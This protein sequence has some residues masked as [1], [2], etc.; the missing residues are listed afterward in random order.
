MKQQE[1]IEGV[2]VIIWAAIAFTAWGIVF[3]GWWLV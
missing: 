2:G 1:K 3:L